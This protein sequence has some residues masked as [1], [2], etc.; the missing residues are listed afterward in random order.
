MSGPTLRAKVTDHATQ[1]GIGRAQAL[2]NLH[3][4]L[5]VN[6]YSPEGVVASVEGLMRFSEEVTVKACLHREDS[7]G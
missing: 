3:L 2:G 4:R 6:T 7:A 1:S 5:A